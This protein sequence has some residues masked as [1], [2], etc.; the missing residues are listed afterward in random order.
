MQRRSTIRRCCQSVATQT[1]REGPFWEACR[2]TPLTDSLQE[3]IDLFRSHGRILREEGEVFPVMS[4]LSVMI[5]QNVIPNSHDP[6]VDRLDVAK[7]RLKLDETRSRV[8]D[9]VAAM[10]RHWDFVEGVRLAG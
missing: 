7:I 10:P 5:G 8:R 9:C 1:E 3:K 6:L 2:A 4:W